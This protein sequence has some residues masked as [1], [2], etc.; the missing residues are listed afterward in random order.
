MKPTASL[1]SR[2]LLS[3]GVLMFCTAPTPGDIGGCGQEAKELDAPIFFATK[4]HVDCERC[5][6]CELFTQS[7]AA[8]CDGSEQPPDAFPEGCVPVVQ[9]GFAC[10]R[11]LSHASCDDYTEYM[12]D[13]APSVPTE[14]NFCPTRE[15]R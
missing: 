1:L 2:L 13:R 11:A 10:L 15:P 8:A 12:D 7:C 3:L 4:K 6:D 5:R 14:C 9:D